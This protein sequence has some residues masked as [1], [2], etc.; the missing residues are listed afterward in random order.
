M[1]FSIISFLLSFVS[2]IKLL[3]LEMRL[4]KELDTN[5]KLNSIICSL[6]SL[7][8][9]NSHDFVQFQQPFHSPL[10]SLPSFSDE[11]V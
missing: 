10:P 11:C 9:R 1:F 2:I 7:N 5:Q 3:F 8:L 4:N 6:N